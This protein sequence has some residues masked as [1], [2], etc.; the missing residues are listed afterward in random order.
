MDLTRTHHST[1]PRTNEKVTLNAKN[2]CNI[3]EDAITLGWIGMDTEKLIEQCKTDENFRKEVMACARV[4]LNPDT[5]DHIMATIEKAREIGKRIEVEYSMLTM[6]ELKEAIRKLGIERIPKAIMFV[7]ESNGAGGITKVVYI[8]RNPDD[9]SPHGMYTRAVFFE[10]RSTVQHMPLLQAD[11]AVNLRA[12]AGDCFMNDVAKKSSLPPSKTLHGW[13][14]RIK[15]ENDKLRA[16]GLVE[17]ETLSDAGSEDS[18]DLAGLE[19]LLNEEG[20]QTLSAR[21]RAQQMLLQA[22]GGATSRPNR[23][24]DKKKETS[25]QRTSEEDKFMQD[26]KVLKT[27]VGGVRIHSGADVG[28]ELNCRPQIA[29]PDFAFPRVAGQAHFPELPVS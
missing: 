25:G 16:A 24:T 8:Q 10:K 14:E 1:D 26:I 27:S 28:H 23:P 17:E 12:G 6:N 21:D 29:G 3:C 20:K 18:Q 15:E 5:A 2:C 4:L 7:R 9:D 22:R 19:D 11:A 13:A